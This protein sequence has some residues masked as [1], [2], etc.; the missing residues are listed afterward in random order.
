MQPL[1]I[2]LVEDE[3]TTRLAVAA[4]LAA[5]EGYRVLWQA[6][7]LDQGMAELHRQPPQLLIVDLGLPDG[8]GLDLIAAARRLDPAIGILVLTVFGDEQ[9]LI[10]AIEQGAR[11]YLLKDE[12]AIGLVDA[13]EQLRAGGAPM[14]PA[15]ARHLVSRLLRREVPPPLA[16]QGVLTA[17]EVEVL[18]LA[19]KG[20]NHAEVARLLG[21]SAHT[22][23]SYT[24]R[25][26]EKLEVRSR[27]EALFEARRLGLL[28]H[29]R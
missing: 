9:K 26:Y 1:A 18:E 28:G 4:R 10:R 19:A 24:R 2:A 15:I 13:I 14:S 23:A 7:R 29:G 22:V 16:E 5:V 25:I 6:E 21:L 11:G 8:S 3:P 17:R 20:Y 12:P 27:A